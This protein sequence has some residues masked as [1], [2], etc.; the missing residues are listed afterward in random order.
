MITIS[1]ISTDNT[2]TPTSNNK[3]HHRHNDQSTVCET[4]RARS[5][6]LAN[7]MVTRAALVAGLGEGCNQGAADVFRVRDLARQLRRLDIAGEELED[8][9]LQRRERHL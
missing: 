5:T 6:K 2:N 9:R 8:E 4:H 3:Y 7:Q 1:S